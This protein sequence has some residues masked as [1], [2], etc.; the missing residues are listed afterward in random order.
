MTCFSST[1]NRR[2]HVPRAD[3]RSG[4]NRAAR[5][6]PPRGHGAGYPH[7]DD[8]GVASTTLVNQ[9]QV[10]PPTGRLRLRC[11]SVGAPA[12]RRTPAEQ[13]STCQG[14]YVPA[15]GCCIQHPDRHRT[16]GR[17]PLPHFHRPTISQR[18][19][20]PLPATNPTTHPA[21]PCSSPHGRGQGLR[22]SISGRSE[23]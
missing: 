19:K 22:P 14:I 16:A 3:R 5:R 9:I 18:P 15:P 21:H 10:G 23:S 17:R 8:A 12:R 2:L 11:A 13:T 20:K 1:A 6:G 4:V 7:V